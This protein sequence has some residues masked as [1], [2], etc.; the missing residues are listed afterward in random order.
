[1]VKFIGSRAGEASHCAQ[2][3][4]P[5]LHNHLA[6]LLIPCNVTLKPDSASLGKGPHGEHGDK[7]HTFILLNGCSGSE[8]T[9]L[10]NRY[11]GTT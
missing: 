9:L 4:L 8:L 2:D 10:D 1:M 11:G 7:G 3:E 5:I 6:F